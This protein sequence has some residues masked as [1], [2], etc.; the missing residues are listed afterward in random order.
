MNEIQPAPI[1][2]RGRMTPGARKMRDFLA[3]KPGAPLY[4]REFGYYSLDKWKADGHIP[5]D[6]D[7]EWMSQTFL[8]DDPGVHYN[9]LGGCEAPFVPEFEVKVLED[10]GE[11]ELV[12]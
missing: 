11:H 8:F 7:W 10:R 6:A 3:L 4:R 12:Q 1:P 5:Q 9:Y 2:P